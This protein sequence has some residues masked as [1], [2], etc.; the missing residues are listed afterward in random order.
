MSKQ[1]KG[2]VKPVKPI[3]PDKS[4]PLRETKNIPLKRETPKP[5][6]G[7]GRPPKK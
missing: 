6:K 5:Q 4:S 2:P 1:Q 3:K 7:A